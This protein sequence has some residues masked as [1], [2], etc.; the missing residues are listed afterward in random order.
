MCGI[1]GRLSINN[2]DPRKTLEGIKELE[3]RGYDSYGILMYNCLTEESIYEK[4]IGELDFMDFHKFSDIKSNIELGHT[5]W[6]THGGIS[7]NNA[8]PQ[9]D[10]SENFFV[11]MNGIV[12]N[13]SEVRERLKNFGHKFISDTDTEV[14]PMLYSYFFE[15]FGDI[16]KSLIEASKKVIQELQG[17]FSFL[18]KYKN[19]VLGYKN[20]NP[21]IFGIGNDELFISSDSNLVQKNSE[22]HFIL[23]DDEFFLAS[24]IDNNLSF[25]FYNLAFKRISKQSY[26]SEHIFDST[27][28]LTTYYME[29]EI[30]EQRDLK[31][32]ITPSNLKSISY[33]L[34]R[35]KKKKRIIL[36]GAGTSYHAAIFLH[37]RLLSLG[38]LS[39]LVIASELKNYANVIKNSLVVVFSQS[40]ETADLIYPLKELK[41]KNEIFTVTNSINSTLDRFATNSVYLNC[42]KEISVASTKAFTSQI[43]FSKVIENLYIEEDLGVFIER[44]ERDFEEVISNNQGVL[45]NICFD[46]R[47]QKSFFFIGRNSYYPLALEGA[48]KLKEISYIHAEGFAGGE[49]K[50]GSL[51]LIE[52]GVPVVVIG[53]DSEILSNALE[54]KTRCGII[55]GIG[56]KNHEI[57]DYYLEVPENFKA[58]FTVI[59]MQILSLKM[60]LVLGFNPDK[61]RNLAKSVTVK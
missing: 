32:F 17:E 57:Y 59:L 5:R 28:K 15:D 43:F 47:D 54:I 56:S 29:K 2:L 33:L 7:I 46:F 30:L 9:F 14:I 38:I 48:L 19:Y 6:A 20:I 3:Y 16:R 34:D 60:T 55:I 8:H 44:Y 52:S 51:A 22:L 41:K 39:Q 61:P 1:I 49:L 40:G 45:D 37:Y 4:N 31:N 25:E 36:T 53:D 12:E 21:L 10:S 13:F 26:K 18:L 11:V 35:I 58:I 42:E 27:E 23:D 24:V 50:H